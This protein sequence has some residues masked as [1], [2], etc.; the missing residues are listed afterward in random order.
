M[1]RVSGAN[2]FLWAVPVNA[3]AASQ[4]LRLQLLLDTFYNEDILIR[5]NSGRK[6]HF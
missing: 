2:L 4:Y 6:N 3:N 5:F 1:P